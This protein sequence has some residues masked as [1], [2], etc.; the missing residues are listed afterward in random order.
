MAQTYTAP[1]TTSRPRIP[2]WVILVGLVL[3]VGIVLLILAAPAL[4]NAGDQA[5]QGYF[6]PYGVDPALIR[7]C[8]GENGA[9]CPVV[10]SV[11]YSLIF[12]IAILTGFAYTTL[13]ERK[14]IA[15]FQQR[16]GPNRVGPA[17]L[18]QPAADG[19]KLI[20]KEDIIPSGADKP[21]YYLAPVLKAV[22]AFIVL[23][24]IPFGPMLTVPWFD[25]FWYRVPLGLADPNV[26]VL[27]L[28]AITSLGTYGVVLAGWASNNKYAMLGGLR[29]SA[30]MLSYEL[31][32]GLTMAVPILIVGSM[33]LGDIVGSQ[34]YIW[35]WFIFQN[36]LACGI[37]MI[38]LLAEVN[39]SPFD[40]PEAEQELTQGFMTE[41]S[42][43][44]FAM[45]MLSEYIGM[46]AISVIV[47]SLFLGGYNDGFGIVQNIPI[48]GPIVLLGKVVVF[49]IGMVWVRATLPRIRYDRL[50]ALGWKVLLPLA[51]VA[52]MW[53]AV[54]ILLG[55]LFNSPI[56]YGIA[57][58]VFFVVVIGGS[59][60]VLRRDDEP[61]EQAAWENDPVITGER[62]GLGYV[63]LQVIGGLIA[64]PFAL[65]KGTITLLEGLAKLAPE[66]QKK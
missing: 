47:A 12:L 9:G 15:W 33:S 11:A 43:M 48:L 61:D 65:L 59:W 39:R 46:I 20:F 50:M 53:S 38:A 21:V 6:N 36:P 66:E 28:L 44:K 58:A 60:L 26:G 2:R 31:S 16:T 17:G 51:L 24:V 5:L 22:P 54:A 62:R 30:Q 25:G 45:F 42:A 29:A 63:G 13:L 57:G 41:Y 40:L 37:L 3:V 8:Y 27:W 14:F 19:V 34:T 7:E 52:V 49:L 56:A 4:F 32:L 23:A 35:Q 18:L 55:D 10:H 64:I 1:E